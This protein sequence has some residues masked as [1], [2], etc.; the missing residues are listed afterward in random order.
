MTA[1]R[2]RPASIHLML[3]SKTQGSMLSFFA[4]PRSPDSQFDEALFVEEALPSRWYATLK[5]AVLISLQEF[6]PYRLPLS[7][8]LSDTCRSLT[9][10][11][12]NCPC[13]CCP[14][15]KAPILNILLHHLRI[16]PYSVPAFASPPFRSRHLL[17]H[18]K[19]RPDS[20]L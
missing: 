8:I 20:Q 10:R 14:P 2:L 6:R 5:A 7:R 3:E 9:P 4:S 15:S 13:P 1:L 17:P 16:N 12:L 11:G 18:V 19:L